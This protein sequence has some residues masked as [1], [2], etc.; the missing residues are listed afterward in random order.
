[1]LIAHLFQEVVL[2]YKNRTAIVDEYSSLS[3]E[4]INIQ[5]NQLASYLLS[6]GLK[7]QTPIGVLAYR[8][9]NYIIAIL[10]I[11][12]T[13]CFYVPLDPS[14]PEERLEYIITETKMSFII[15]STEKLTPLLKKHVDKKIYFDSHVISKE[16]KTNITIQEAS[17]LDNMYVLFTS[18]STGKP[19][20]VMVNQ[21]G[22]INLVK[23]F[24]QTFKP[25]F[26]NYNSCQNARLS[27]DASTLEI[28]YHLLSGATIY[29]TPESILLQS[30]KLRDWI[31][32][33]EIRE[34]LLV[35]PLAEM[36]FEQRFPSDCSFKYL[37]LGGDT[38]KKLPPPDF[39][40]Q[41][42]NVY[43]PTE[44]AC[45]TVLDTFPHGYQGPITIGKAII[46]T[47]IYIIDES[48]AL[49][50]TGEVGELCLAGASVGNGYWQLPEQTAAAFLRDQEINLRLGEE[51]IYRTGDL[52][53]E[54]EDGRLDFRG[55]IDFQVKIRGLRIELNEI[56]QVILKNPQI[57]QV[58]VLARGEGNDKYLVAYYTSKNKQKVKQE[59]IASF[60]QQELPDYM[61]PKFYLHLEAIPL[62][63]NNKTDRV[64]LEKIELPY[65]EKMVLAPTNQIQRDILA[66]WNSFLDIE[67]ISIDDNFFYIGGHSLKAAQI[68]N[69][70]QQ[71]GYEIELSQFMLHPT[72]NEL[73]GIVRITGTGQAEI[74]IIP[75]DKDN[76]II[77][78]NQEDLW[79][80]SHL[81]DSS[82]TYNIVLKCE[83]LDNIDVPILTLSLEQLINH[84]EAFHS[85]F[86]EISKTVYQRIEPKIK[87]NCETLKIATE[88]ELLKI[89]E[90]IQLLEYQV[91]EYPLHTFKIVILD[92]KVFLFINV[93]HLIFD[94]WSMQIFIARLNDIYY[95]IND[96][97]EIIEVSEVQNID[98]A[99]W[100]SK[101]P[102]DF[103][104]DKEFW[105]EQLH[106][107]S[108]ALM[109]TEDRYK[110]KFLTHH[111]TR[112]WFRINQ[113]E[114]AKLSEYA[115]LNS[116]SLFSMLLTI[117]QIVLGY[118][119]KRSD[120]SVAFPYATRNSVVEENL[121]G[122]YTNMV[123][124]RSQL[125]NKSF[126]QLFSATHRKI[127]EAI[128]HSSMPF[129]SL[130]KSFN[131]PLDKSQTPLYQAMFVMQNWHSEA[132]KQIITG[133]VEIGSKTSKTDITLNA[134][135]DQEGME[136]WLEYNPD[137]LSKQLIENMR[138][139]YLEIIESLAPPLIESNRKSCF[140]ITE[141]TLGIKCAELLLSA[142]YHIYGVI[143]STEQ[144]RNW[145]IKH[146]IYTADF[147]KTKLKH[148]L[149]R[150]SYEYLFSIVNDIVL[151]KEI[152]ATP[153]KYS[154]NY[155]DSLLPQYA[156]L[157]ATFWAIAK[158]AT[159]HGITWHKVN[160][161]IDTG[162]IL[163][164]SEVIIA[165]NDTSSSLNI[166]CYEAAINSFSILITK[167]DHN[168]IISKPQDLQLRSYYSYHYRDDICCGISE[169][170][171]LQQVERLYRAVKLG[172]IEN[173]VTTL[174]IKLNNEFYLI[175]E[176]EF[177]SNKKQNNL[178]LNRENKQLEIG[179]T[180]GKIKIKELCNLFGEPIIESEFSTIS[181]WETPLASDLDI[182]NLS[183]RDEHFW[184]TQMRD[185]IPLEIPI[186]KRKVT[187]NSKNLVLDNSDLALFICFL[188]RF[189]NQSAFSI[190][191]STD[192]NHFLLMNKFPIKFTLDFNATIKENLTIISRKLQRVS[193]KPNF[194]KDIL[195]RYPQY[196]H[197]SAVIK[198][199]EIIDDDELFQT[200]RD[201]CQANPLLK[202]VSLLN[203]RE[204]LQIKTW[205][206]KQL[207]IPDYSYLD[208]FKQAVEKYPNNPAIEFGEQQL[209]YRQ[210][211]DKSDSLAS[212][213]Y[214][215]YGRGEFI[216]ILTDRCINM[217]VVILAILKSGNAYLP[218]DPNY[219]PDRIKHILENSQSKLI[220]TDQELATLDNNIILS[221]ANCTKYQNTMTAEIKV[222]PYDLA[223]VI[224]TSGSTGKPKGVMVNHANLV[225]HNLIVKDIYRLT[226]QDR[227]LQF[228]SISFDISIEEMFPTWISGANLVLREEEINR[229]ASQF[230]EFIKA[231]RI[232]ILDLPTA[233]W[234]Q[235][236]KVLP[237][238]KL[239]ESVKCVIIGGEKA[240]AEVY[241]HWLKY[242]SPTVQVFN[243][244]GPT[245]TTIIATID[246]GVDDTIGK[247]M[248]NSQIHILDSFMYPVPVGV[249]GSIF[250]GGKGV[251]PGYFNNEPLTDKLF[252]EHE[253]YGRIYSSGDLGL[254]LESGK[255]KFLGRDDDQIKLS[256]YRIEL[257]EIENVFLQN[258]NLKT[259]F[260]DVREDGN[261]K[262]IFLYYLNES[263]IPND[264]FESIA[265][266]FLP[267]YMKPAGYQ[268]ITKLPL[269]PNGKIDKK[270]L[271]NFIITESIINVE[272]YNLY[273]MKLLPLFCEVLGKEIGF[274]D[275][276]FKEGGDSLKAIELL[277]SLE[278]ALDFKVSSSALYQYATVR[279]ISRYLL[280]ERESD[281]SIIIP[282]QV[283]N[284]DI[285]PLFLAHT[286]P[287]DVLGYVNLIH[288]LD[289]QI[290]VYG[291]QSAEFDQAKCHSC[292]SEMI[293]NYVNEILKIQTEPPFYI[294]GWC[295]GG[296][297]AFEIGAELKRRG[298]SE[299]NLYL[300]ETW[301]RP[302]S[303]VRKIKYQLR[304]VSSAV[305]LGP[306]FWTSYLTSKLSNFSNIHKVLEDDFIDNIT[307]T[308]GG[309][310][311][312]EIDKLK[313]IYRYN[314]NALNKHTMSDFPGEINLFLAEK[315]LEG[316]IPDPKY[317]WSGLVSKVNFFT[318]KGS[319][320]T[321]LKHPFVKDI[322]GV[323]S[324]MLGN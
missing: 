153:L 28:W 183:V 194:A 191:V 190:I 212:Y 57:E 270:L 266:L 30:A 252:I 62:T 146:G 6:L 37:Y 115:K 90:D 41:I 128:S 99:A 157:Y 168:E 114:L 192:I 85:S 67:K 34:I 225:N 21:R 43:G 287:G 167:L 201:N 236:A 11:I 237:Q 150:F 103:T 79:Y 171:T 305:A 118:I 307:E 119:S 232:T 73:S 285:K 301:G 14:Y 318:V 257:A 208:L 164:Q 180:D 125:Y 65:T 36:L 185:F 283:G 255:I 286:T 123:I 148:L 289:K 83:L 91:D 10:A 262:K 20:G 200:F 81:D 202:D 220:F 308:L 54:L 40:A 261:N 309:K 7:P 253:S 100:Q 229:S 210:L 142:G 33:K 317:G 322:A 282:L 2:K 272:A 306:K 74:P 198:S 117:Y 158:G 135:E 143:S 70:M 3:Y 127:M 58:V 95:N 49:V 76:N 131:L 281:F 121:I 216:A 298:Y 77:T 45:I 155:H 80:L 233:F 284:K 196:H 52:V 187:H 156:G 133:E 56:E 88:E 110:S 169:Q 243:T 61:V 218:I 86:P 188:A 87:F 112:M 71:R 105:H 211:D 226:P 302:N 8:D 93:H 246:E 47:R 316:I 120:I 140:I 209:T 181:T 39:K 25:P 204:Q 116:V 44:C 274:E 178:T 13:N 205:N 195:Y 259:I 303:K 111:G 147:N 177:V 222:S 66:I 102:S 315:P 176:A 113:Q 244:Y 235:I 242:V 89:T 163:T 1:M 207:T 29:F 173:P 324:K 98:Y 288:A 221:I 109:L 256:G 161:G 5:A 92:K 19:K 154:I 23:H 68:V 279:G 189:S 310:S 234:H 263:A 239:P 144:V 278:R 291:I 149:K 320:M 271:P 249:A 319:H 277:V 269:N 247:V 275:N 22:V 27:F 78:K 203:D 251:T 138:D 31:V 186:H 175:T 46:N 38:L 174:K 166:K 296:V 228:A 48:L 139:K 290:P 258:S 69:E 107:Y 238:E 213:L 129:G 152:L 124:V 126:E 197:F 104:I 141:T 224:Y 35:T 130:L 12:K 293:H 248:P 18:G 55:R 241:Q 215:N 137:L 136:F 96:S 182:Y 295:F 193:N 300:I 50:N 15:G 179:L 106:P 145:S 63:S 206:T 297:I 160:E 108:P 299:I 311:Q 64:A 24:Q 59:E 122:Y 294:G 184:I 101:N 231:K 227:V 170:H 132:N 267:D 230:Y 273:E 276:F 84:Y 240:S 17:E 214:N 51:V 217:A 223:Y 60:V 4:D 134:E 162:D 304:R 172:N 250:I 264:Y 82:R 280:E 313:R 53:R 199:F 42:V 26:G 321:V 268:Q 292:F 151:D 94:G 265:D 75:R 9:C 97:Q 72:I 260:V 312:A 254:Y 245:E 165:P 219:P 323:I 314:I 16:P 32:E 159:L